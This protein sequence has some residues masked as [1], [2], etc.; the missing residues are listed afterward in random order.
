MPKLSSAQKTTM[1]SH[2]KAGRNRRIRSNIKTN[3]GKGEALIQAHDLEQAKSAASEAIGGLDRAANKGV[4][5]RNNAA[6]HKARLMKKL[7]SS[8]RG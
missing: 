2:R 4:I 7:N 5:H 6:R 8:A 1:A 3:V